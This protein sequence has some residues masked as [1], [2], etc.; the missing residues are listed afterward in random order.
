MRRQQ[1]RQNRPLV[2]RTLTVLPLSLSLS[3]SSLLPFLD[4]A[5][6]CACGRGAATQTVLFVRRTSTSSSAERL[7]KQSGTSSVAHGMPIFHF[8]RH[9]RNQ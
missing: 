1:R 4:F 5:P 2:D 6:T 8:H 7:K 9:Q 3:L